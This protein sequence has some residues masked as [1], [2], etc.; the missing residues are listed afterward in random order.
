M[1]GSGKISIVQPFSSMI[2]KE[3]LVGTSLNASGPNVMNI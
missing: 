2:T 1:S 3:S